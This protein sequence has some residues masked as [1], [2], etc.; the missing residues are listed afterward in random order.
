M[1]YYYLSYGGVD[2]E[3]IGYTDADWVGHLEHHKSTSAYAFLLNRDVSW[4]S[5]K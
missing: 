1:G 4:A 3:L 2:L 5:K